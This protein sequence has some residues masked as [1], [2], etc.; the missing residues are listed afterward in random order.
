MTTG[1]QACKVGSTV[2]TLAI[3]SK[4]LKHSNG[5]EKGV[6][7]MVACVVQHGAKFSARDGEGMNAYHY[8][9]WK[10]IWRKELLDSTKKMLLSLLA[11][12]S[13]EYKLKSTSAA[14][15]PANISAKKNHTPVK[16]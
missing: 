2:G 12:E 10:V 6:Y 11:Q 4:I 15:N 16:R 1:W 5:H 9:F 3:L 8:F 14:M 13:K 7:D